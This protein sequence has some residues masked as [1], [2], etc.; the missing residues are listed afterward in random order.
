M[1]QVMLYRNHGAAKLLI[2]KRRFQQRSNAIT[3]VAITQPIQHQ[4]HIRPAPDH[5]AEALPKIGPAILIDRNMIDIGQRQP[6]IFKAP[7]NGLAGEA[8]P[9]LDP[10]KAFLFRRCNKF[11]V[12]YDAGSRIGMESV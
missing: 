9:M 1:R 7:G 11:A 6:G 3:L 4:P 12:S 5:I 2:R 8:S 10:A